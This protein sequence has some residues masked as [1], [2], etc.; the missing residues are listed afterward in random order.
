MKYMVGCFCSA[1]LGGLFAFWLLDAR[2]PNGVLAQDGG[3]ARGPGFGQSPNA[4]RQPFRFPSVYTKDQLSPGEAISIAVYENVNKSVVHITT[5]SSRT[6]GFFFLEV[7][8]E[9]HLVL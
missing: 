5:K 2:L 7:P 9:G 6:D 3:I 1:V 4:E 8:A